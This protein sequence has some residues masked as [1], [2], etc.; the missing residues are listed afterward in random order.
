MILW[1]LRLT[2][3]WIHRPISELIQIDALSLIFDS[4]QSFIIPS[5]SLMISCKLW[6]LLIFQ[7][8]LWFVEKLTNIFWFSRKWQPRILNWNLINFADTIKELLQQYV[9][10]LIWTSLISQNGI[11]TS[12]SLIFKSSGSFLFW[13]QRSLIWHEFAS[14]SLWGLVSCII[15]YLKL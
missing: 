5:I 3:R 7:H 2:Y 1:R 9:F 10:L 11:R 15:F 13:L 6:F 14:R 12:H 4:G 8:L